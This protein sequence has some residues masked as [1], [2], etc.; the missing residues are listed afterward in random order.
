MYIPPNDKCDLTEK[1]QKKLGWLNDP[2]GKTVCFHVLDRPADGILRLPPATDGKNF[3]EAWYK[4][5]KLVLCTSNDGYE[6]DL[7]TEDD[8]VDKVVC[9]FA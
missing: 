6:I 8:G 5:R 4:C 3:C 7:P 9:I 2:D 1:E